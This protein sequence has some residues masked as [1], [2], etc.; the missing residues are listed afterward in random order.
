MDFTL[1]TFS[2]GQ[3]AG[4]I[5]VE[6]VISTQV[7]GSGVVTVLWGG[8]MCKRLFYKM[9]Y[10]NLKNKYKYPLHK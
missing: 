4:V 10:K 9:K 5:N 3:W 6:S 2:F 7:G 1:S 8:V